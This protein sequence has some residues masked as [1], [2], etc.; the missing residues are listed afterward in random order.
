MLRVML[1]KAKLFE[2]KLN[3]SRQALNIYKKALT[4]IND[5]SQLDIANATKNELRIEIIKS[6]KTCGS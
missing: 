2:T 6:M 3:N 4:I 1:F 5:S